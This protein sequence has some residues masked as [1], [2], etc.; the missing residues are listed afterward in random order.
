MKLRLLLAVFTLPV[1]CSAATLE[2][3]AQRFA[4]N[5]NVRYENNQL[6]IYGN[7]YYYGPGDDFDGSRGLF[8]F[9]AAVGL[10]WYGWHATPPA[11][12]IILGA[13]AVCAGY[14][15]NYLA[16]YKPRPLESKKVPKYIFNTQ[17][18]F[19]CSA[20]KY[21]LIWTQYAKTEVADEYEIIERTNYV[22]PR[23]GDFDQ[24]VRRTTYHE[25]M[26]VGERATCRGRY[27]ER[28][29]SSRTNAFEISATDLIDIM[30]FFKR[31]YGTK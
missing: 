30:E 27:N 23:P 13:A 14:G 1:F 17:G 11:N 20:D 15:C 4:S 19:D 31:E 25:R 26:R 12:A 18:F 6:V 24:T 29:W 3:F 7:H 22:Y 9:M 21:L 28:L 10:G 5:Q 16:K 8:P 2:Q